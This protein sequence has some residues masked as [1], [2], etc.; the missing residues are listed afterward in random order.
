M[1]CPH[2]CI[3]LAVF[4]G[5]AHEQPPVYESRKESEERRI[6]A[7]SGHEAGITNRESSLAEYSQYRARLREVVDEIDSLQ[8]EG[9]RFLV[10]MVLE[11]TIDGIRPASFR[12]TSIRGA[13]QAQRVPGNVGQHVP[14]KACG[15]TNLPWSR[16]VRPRAVSPRYPLAGAILQVCGSPHGTRTSNPAG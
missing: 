16:A 4:L 15:R 2:G 5:N 6:V 12:G 11:E 10:E 9:D 3:F 13:P 14:C 7:G 8:E 1:E